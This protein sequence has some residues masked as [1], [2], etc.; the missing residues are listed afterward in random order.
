MI[1]VYTGNGKGKTTA[2]L[3][4]AVRA[5]GAGLKVYIAQFCKGKNYSELKILK[6]I[7]NIKVEQLGSGC[8]IK[9]MPNQKDIALAKN[10]L[11]KIKRIIAKRTYDLVIL[12]EI[13][14]ALELGLLALKDIL[15]LIKKI[16][17]KT[18]IILT[19]RYAH[20]K[21]IKIADL[22]SEV[23][24]RKHYYKKGVKARRGIEF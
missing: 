21:I 4:L 10:G 11:L 1:Q 15:D 14:I 17:R 13:N 6:R 20:P 12:D 8:F 3:G 22:V 24:E 9:K 7:K 23:K 19:G 5:A 2:A 18:E 16:P